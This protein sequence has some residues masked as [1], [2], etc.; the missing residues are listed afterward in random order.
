V[1]K[2]L[3]ILSIFCFSCTSKKE[4]IKNKVT[5]AV[6]GTWT[7]QVTDTITTKAAG[8]Y[9]NVYTWTWIGNSLDT[10][11]IQKNGTNLKF[12]AS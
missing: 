9:Q 1:K 12:K 6:P 10:P 2:L 5:A 4:T 11:K 7:W 8:S 3:I